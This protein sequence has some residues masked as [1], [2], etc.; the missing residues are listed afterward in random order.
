M[1]IGHA[2]TPSGTAR[3]KGVD[4]LTPRGGRDAVADDG[5]PT[6]ATN[7]GDEF[8]ELIDAHPTTIAK[9]AGQRHKAAS[10]RRCL[11]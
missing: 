11:S 5:D 4:S 2:A 9:G 3:D 8:R 1:T 6:G 7:P 10:T